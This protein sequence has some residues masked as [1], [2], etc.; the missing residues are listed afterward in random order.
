MQSKI[1]LSF[2]MER[3]DD[4]KLTFR[5]LVPPEDHDPFY[6]AT[7]FENLLCKLSLNL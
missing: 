2:Q 4:E 7:V 1:F 6:A 5:E 3:V